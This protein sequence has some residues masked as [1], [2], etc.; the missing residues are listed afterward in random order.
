MRPPPGKVQ[1]GYRQE[2]ANWGESRFLRAAQAAFLVLVTIAQ[3]LEAHDIADAGTDAAQTV[4]A[5]NRD[6]PSD[7]EEEVDRDAELEAPGTKCY[8]RVT[9][10]VKN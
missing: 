5:A 8:T 7:E 1:N 9:Q 4:D 3:A 2:R 10:T 6:G